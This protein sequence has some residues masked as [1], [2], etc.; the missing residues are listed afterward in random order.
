MCCPVFIQGVVKEWILSETSWIC[1]KK[2][3]LK[4][5]GQNGTGMISGFFSFSLEKKEKN[6][7]DSVPSSNK[8][9]DVGHSETASCSFLSDLKGSVL[10]EMRL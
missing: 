2:K 3:N 6:K 1:R 8:K 5:P 10:S 4:R 7:L 9:G